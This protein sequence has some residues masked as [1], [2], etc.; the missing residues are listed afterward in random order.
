LHCHSS[1]AGGVGRLAVATLSERPRV[2]YSPH[3]LAANVAWHYLAI[4]RVLAG[5]TDRFAAI[6]ESELEEI[7]RFGLAQPNRVDVISPIVD[8]EHYAE[9]DQGSARRQ[10]GLAPGPLILGV[11]RFI[12]QKDPVGF[13]RTFDA[14]RR[15]LPDAHGVW[16]GEGELQSD[17][18]REIVERGLTE[19]LR[20]IPWQLDV[21]PWVAAADLVVS[22]ARFESF[23]YVV[24][25]AMAMHRC[26]VASRITGTVDV[27]QEGAAE[28]LYTA[29]D[30][31][32]A[33]EI[34]VKLLKD[35]S[36]REN[37]AAQ[38]ASRIRRVFSRAAMSQRLC[39]VYSQT[40]RSA[41]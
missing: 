17:V 35:R 38:G 30:Y 9:R 28:L 25:E 41:R 33:A 20:I 4:E 37:I 7:T 18:E 11:G 15:Q 23:G 36:R 26:V 21:R 31:D 12:H 24:A 22:T 10:L 14:I 27:V 13:V 8:G 1:K 29:G 5:L 16:V 2:I 40:S 39:S 19:T 6:S 3:A 32:A 34:V